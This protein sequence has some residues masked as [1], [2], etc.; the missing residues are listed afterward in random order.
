M[1]NILSS[2][3]ESEKKRILE[4]HY[5]ASN[6]HYLNEQ[7]PD[8]AA[9]TTPAGPPAPATPAVPSTKRTDTVKSV[10]T[11]T[12]F[13]YDPKGPIDVSFNFA[14]G[15]GRLSNRGTGPNTGVIGYFCEKSIYLNNGSPY[16]WISNPSNDQSYGN[17]IQF[18]RTYNSKKLLKIGEFF[19]PLCTEYAK[20]NGFAGDNPT[21]TYV[22]NEE[23]NQ[24]YLASENLASAS[25]TG[26]ET[27]TNEINK[28]QGLKPLICR[29]YAAKQYLSPDFTKYTSSL[30]NILSDIDVY[31]VKPTNFNKLV[32]LSEKLEAFCKS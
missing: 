23:L 5:K 32:D 17:P 31:S 4:M 7:T 6:R 10:L 22:S 25:R 19:S 8:P 2:L 18:N 14:T 3:N 9:P 20:L 1:K 11:D 21:T 16:K 26:G 30:K 24:V 13:Y 28:I 29:Y 12:G 27:Y 15:K